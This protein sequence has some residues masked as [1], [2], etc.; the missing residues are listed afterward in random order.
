VNARI[1]RGPPRS[2]DGFRVIAERR[3]A[4]RGQRRDEILHQAII[5]AHLMYPKGDLV[6]APGVPE[7]AR[8]HREHRAQPVVEHKTFSSASS[9]GEGGIAAKE[10]ELFVPAQGL[11]G[12]AAECTQLD[13]RE[14][15]V[16][17]IDER[18]LGLAEKT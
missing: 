3:N 8:L 5:A 1:G 18:D 16:D 11:H 6:G 17:G 4:H 15:E 14:A 10:R 2:I 7:V 12:R 9:P 13:L